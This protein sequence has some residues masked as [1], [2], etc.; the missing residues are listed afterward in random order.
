MQGSGLDLGSR[1]ECLGC[2]VSGKERGF[3]V[4]GLGFRVQG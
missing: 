1:V 2:G 3:I 4:H